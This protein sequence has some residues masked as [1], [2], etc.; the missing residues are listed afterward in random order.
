MDDGESYL[1]HDMEECTDADGRLPQITFT[2]IKDR[3]KLFQVT[4]WDVHKD[5][6]GWRINANPGGS[7]KLAVDVQNE[8][9]E[10]SRLTQFKFELVD[11][12][13][14]PSRKKKR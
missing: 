7:D 13:I 4:D 12:S 1:T 5:E 14:T 2:T 6:R 8:N 9:S 11:A 3:A 10:L